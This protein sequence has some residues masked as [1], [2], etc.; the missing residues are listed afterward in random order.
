[1]VQSV[2]AEVIQKWIQAALTKM[3]LAIEG[4]TFEN[5]LSLDPNEGD[6][7]R[8]AYVQRHFVITTTDNAANKFCVM[9][10]KHY[11]QLCSNEL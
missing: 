10:K 7:K 4:H 9:C 3:D 1:M 11:S 2:D 8:L 6:L 5:G